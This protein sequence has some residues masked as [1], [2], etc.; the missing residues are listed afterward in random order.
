MGISPMRARREKSKP[1][2]KS[3]SAISVSRLRPTFGD[4]VLLRIARARRVMTARATRSFHLD[5]SEPD[6]SIFNTAGLFAVFAGWKFPTVNRLFQKGF[7]SIGPELAD[8][9]IGFDHGIP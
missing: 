5:Y 4:A 1:G 9:R 7:F 6:L 2:P 3:C 8:V